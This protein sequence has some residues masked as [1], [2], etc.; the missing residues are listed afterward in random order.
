MVVVAVVSG[1]T[2]PNSVV[3]EAAR[4]AD[5]HGTNVHVLYVQGL[6]WYAN[7][8]LVLSGRLGIST[9]IETIREICERKAERIAEP[10]L[11][12]YEAVGLVGRPIAEISQYVRQVD[13]DCVVL[14]SEASLGAGL[15][16]LSWDP[17]KEL[18]EKGIPVVPVY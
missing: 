3:V 15:K 6:S 1:T 10:V 2:K 18:R 11:D 9:G 13:G 17:L 4:Q 16:S 7:L 8:E 14:D 12:D 5:D